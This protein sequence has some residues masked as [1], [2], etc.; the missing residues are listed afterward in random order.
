M[1]QRVEVAVDVAV[2]GQREAVPGEIQAGGTH[3][4]GHPGEH[5]VPARR[6]RVRCG[7]GLHRG[8]QA[9]RASGAHL[10]RRGQ[11]LHRADVVQ[12][13]P[14]VPRTPPSPK[15]LIQRIELGGNVLRDDTGLIAA[16]VMG[17]VL[18]VARGVDI[19]VRRP[20]AGARSRLGPGHGDVR[21]PANPAGSCPGT[22][23]CG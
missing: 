22:T 18:A 1:A 20:P 8:G 13:A 10:P 14:A 7:R 3:L 6:Q 19:P 9:H 2:H 17:L 21:Q 15:P 5:L 11:H 12:R 16:I 4:T 23:H